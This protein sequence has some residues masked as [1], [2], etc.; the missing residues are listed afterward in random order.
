MISALGDARGSSQL[1]PFKERFDP[2]AR[3]LNVNGSLYGTT[4]QGGANYGGTVFSI[5][6]D[7]TEKVLHSFDYNYSFPQTGGSIPKAGLTNVKG[8][9]YGTTAT[10]GA[11]DCGGDDFCG[12][13]FSITTSGMFK[14]MYSFGTGSGDGSF[15]QAALLNVD[16]TLYGTTY[17]GGGSKC[18]ILITTS[19]VETVLYRFKGGTDGAHPGASLTEVSGVLYGS[20][21]WGGEGACTAPYGYTGCGTIFKVTP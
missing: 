11:N 7:G 3:L 21:E 16:G 15:P 5:A 12:T 2:S 14:V 8:T 4:A 17:A 13:V 18:Y 6:P 1:A 10:G 20:T 9:L 19:G